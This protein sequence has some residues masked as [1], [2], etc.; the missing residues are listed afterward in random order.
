VARLIENPTRLILDRAKDLMTAEGYGGL[1]MR[2]L[3]KACGIALGTIY[4]YFPTKRDLVV[5]MMIEHWKGFFFNLES[6]A[7]SEGDFFSRLRMLQAELEQVLSRFR[8]VWL[9]PELYD[10]PDYVEHGAKEG[11]IHVE[12]LVSFIHGM[13]ERELN[14]NGRHLRID[15]LEASRFAVMNLIALMQNPVSTYETFEK[16]L[17]SLVLG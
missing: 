3:S 12:K 11:D 6:I 5:A 17:R 4:N 16:V 15:S 2:H 9:Q 13:W 8:E 14:E 1:S 10:D 7:A